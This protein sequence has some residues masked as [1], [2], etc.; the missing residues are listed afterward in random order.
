MRLIWATVSSVEHETESLQHLTVALD[1][2]SDGLAISYRILG[3]RCM[4][5]DRVLLN[6]T[7]VDLGLGTGGT[8]F[9]LARLG[10]PE[11]V[12]FDTSSGGH[13][14]KL[15]Y[16]PLQTDVFSIEEPNSPHHSVMSAAT[17]LDDMP[18]AC[19]GLH[20]QVPLVAAAVKQV[21]AELKVAYVM[22]DF[23]A[24]P[25]ALS[26]I[27]RAAVDAGLIDGSITCGQAFGGDYEAVNVHSA[28]LA[29]RHVVKADVAIVG[30]GPGVLGTATPFGHGGV[31]QGEAINAVAALGGVPVA[32]LRVSSVDDRERHRGVSH[33]SLTALTRVALA[34]AIVA[35]PRLPTELVRAIEEVLEAGGV[36]QR[37]NRVY[38]ERDD[39]L[40]PEM[41]GLR[42]STMGRGPEDDPVFFAAAYAAGEV[43]AR[44]AN[45]SL[46]LSSL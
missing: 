3:A 32:V 35:M 44:V 1:D 39:C 21:D 7:A 43:C 9:V 6:T 4:L 34:P 20:S 28:L 31:A 15:R 45:G 16:T 40:S 19:C 18:V 22:S 37:H 41:R 33:H 17:E 23:A 13:V 30:V 42:V 27:V 8:H 36:W 26:E 38:A 14:M 25:F 5:G 12:A 46:P 11:G 2:G 10:T 29:S 24:L